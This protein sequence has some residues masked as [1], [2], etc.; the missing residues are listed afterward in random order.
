[1]T[2]KRCFPPVAD[3]HTR[4][5]VLGSLPGEASLA[6]Q[7]YYAH[8]QNRFWH[9]IGDVIGVGDLPTQPYDIR[10]QTLLAHGVGL[11]D[12]VAQARRDG[13]LDS[14]IR[15]HAGNDLVALIE[16]LPN[17]AAVAFNGATAARIG[18]KALGR[19]ADCHPVIHLPSSSPAYTLP[20]AEKLRAWQALGVWVA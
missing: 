20:Y 10:L 8:P 5:L 4:V 16:S 18:M 3:A 1:M 7:Q 13:S 11:W 17:L 6:Q 15:E 12:V 14:R 2:F 19:H 9:L